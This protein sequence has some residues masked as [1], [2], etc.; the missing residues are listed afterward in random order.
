MLARVANSH[1]CYFAYA[2]HCF[3]P[4]TAAATQADPAKDAAILA[5]A[6]KTCTLAQTS[7]K[8]ANIEPT[9]HLC[10]VDT[11]PPAD[12]DALTT[13]PTY[14]Q[15]Q[16]FASL[17]HGRR[18]FTDSWIQEICHRTLDAY[19]VEAQAYSHA[20]PSILASIL[21]TRNKLEAEQRLW[22]D[23]LALLHS[24]L[25]QCSYLYGLHQG[26]LQEAVIY[27]AQQQGA[28]VRESRERARLLYQAIR[29]VAHTA[30]QA[31][32]LTPSINLALADT[33]NNCPDKAWFWST[34]QAILESRCTI[35]LTQDAPRL[36][37]PSNPLHSAVRGLQV[38]GLSSVNRLRH[39]WPPFHSLGIVTGC[40]SNGSALPITAYF[41]GTVAPSASPPLPLPTPAPYLRSTTPDTDPLLIPGSPETPPR[42]P[43]CAHV[44]P[45][46]VALTDQSANASFDL[47]PDTDAHPGPQSFPAAN[48]NVAADLVP[49]FDSLNLEELFDD[50]EALDPSTPP[51]DAHPFQSPP[52]PSPPPT[53]E[54]DPPAATPVLFINRS[55]Y[56]DTLDYIPTETPQDL[57]SR[58]RRHFG[59]TH[60][61][62]DIQ[63]T[64][65]T[66]DGLCHAT[67][68]PV[69]TVIHPF[70]HLSQRPTE[71]PP[72]CPDLLSPQPKPTPMDATDPA[73]TIPSPTPKPQP[74][75]PSDDRWDIAN[76]NPHTGAFAFL[77]ELCKDEKNLAFRPV[78]LDK[79]RLSR[80]DL[81]GAFQALN[82]SIDHRRAQQGPAW[83][84]DAAILTLL[85]NRMV[86][87]AGRTSHEIENKDSWR[88]IVRNRV[89][90]FKEGDLQRLWHDAN[91]AATPPTDPT[92]DGAHPP[93][94]YPTAP[95]TSEDAEYSDPA[96]LHQR[97]TRLAEEACR[98]G[99]LSRGLRLLLN[100]ITA[101]L[102]QGDPDVIRKYG[103][104]AC[105]ETPE[106][107]EPTQE[108]EPS[109]GKCMAPSSGASS[110]WDRSPLKG[111]R[112]KS[113]R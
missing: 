48:P 30:A 34:A 26:D 11:L 24:Q 25:P 29:E 60:S 80:C 79:A 98:K 21:R 6:K 107:F 100:Q 112:K 84:V 57:R 70:T 103:E 66:L 28:S 72:R 40:A 85:F 17:H 94:P 88:S 20:N 68:A 90:R 78:L 56:S 43:P 52:P 41:S 76:T 10:H 37:T 3:L 44:T 82:A 45:P 83:K 61:D 111:Q 13:R 87:H 89:Q 81:R 42:D 27:A 7:R 113:I 108:W 69:E 105:R 9:P 49:D 91:T 109:Y 51:P 23:S 97:I 110:N 4:I 50:L 95:D 53:Y 106:D 74:R 55:P 22:N 64:P 62:Y 47:N 19:T 93:P 63:G 99:N 67:T 46:Q 31:Q 58:I 15:F 77:R 2:T 75:T 1:G 104:K 102:D 92:D 101:P 16:A 54:P 39:I 5:L 96:R 36:L 18:T 33:H 86:L 65:Y 14:H 73:G 32:T 71:G 38:D 35:I 12:P 8:R 59:Y